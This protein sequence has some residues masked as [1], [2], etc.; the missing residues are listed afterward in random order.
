[1]L[2]DAA[3]KSLTEDEEDGGEGGCCDGLG[4]VPDG[5][6]GEGDEAGAEGGAGRPHSHVVVVAIVVAGLL[7]GVRAVVAGDVADAGDEHL[8]E[9]RVHVEEEGLPTSFRSS[10][11]IYYV[12]GME[13]L[14]RCHCMVDLWKA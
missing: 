7:E 14:C 11:C 2:F 3:S 8:A 6:V 12:T 13:Y 4:Q 1:M 5:E 9:R 10:C